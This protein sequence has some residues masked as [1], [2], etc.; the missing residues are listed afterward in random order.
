MRRWLGVAFILVSVA[1]GIQAQALRPLTV[2]D[3]L[4]FR[5]AS[6][7]Q[8]SPDG[9]WVALT[10]TDHSIAENKAVSTI[11]L[12]PSAGGAV[13]PLTVSKGSNHSPR[14][15]T[16]STLAF[17]STRDGESQVWIIDVTGGEARKLTT[18][19]SEVS[20]L[21]VSKDGAW[22]AFD[23]EVYPD[24]IDDDCN[25]RR[26]AEVVKRASKAKVFDRLP[27]RVWN[28]WKDG[29]R[30]HV[31]VQ[32][33]AGGPAKDATPGDFDAPPIDLGGAWDYGFSPDGRTLA[34]SKN[35]DP[36][37]ATSTNNDLFVVPVAGGDARRITENPANDAQ[38]LYAPDGRSIAYL[39]M[40]RPGFEAD[41]RV[42]MLYDVATGSRRAISEATDLSFGEM[43][44]S[45][46]GRYLYASADDRGARSV[47]RIAV[48]DGQVEPLLQEGVVTGLRIAPDGRS[49]YFLH[50]RM[51]RPAELYRMD[52]P[53]KKL[54]KLTGF[55]DER[56]KGLD[57]PAK[58]DVWFQGAGAANVHALLLK[59]PG[60]AAGKTYPLIYLIHG[61][62]QGQ[63]ADQFHYRWS[64]QLFASR[65]F[66]VAMVNPRGSTGYGQAFTDQ[67]SGDWGGA[68]YEDL[69][70]GL[71]H[72]VKAYP[73]IDGKRIAA[74]G[75]SYG[76]Y[77]VN[78]MLGQTDRFRCFVSHDGVF[79]PWSMY[80]TTEELWFTEWE[81]KG[82]PYQ[83]P[84]LY[85]RWS[86]LRNAAKFKTP[87][88]VIH[89]QL[90]YRVDVS[91]GFQLFTA[92]QRQGIPSKMLYFPDEGHWVTKP[93]NAVLWYATVLD[94]IDAH[95]K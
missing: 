84:E 81:F 55:N 19:S 79:N 37:V 94:W 50:D 40:K 18:I 46:D 3:L 26:A 9:R 92:L 47:F 83:H 49:L 4:A 43:A 82:T 57:L 44:W 11:V 56:L 93:A 88:L 75:A 14:W 22:I 66:V 68:V 60:F 35:T 28:S 8:V 53:N 77:M 63:W 13:V 7:P 48:K 1:F 51:H 90:D 33:V 41:R 21:Q 78:W 87:T 70:K 69:I 67:I 31:F 32:S 64:A 12:V 16:T 71:D 73:Y 34:Y 39:A 89:G 38:P 2:E 25:Q 95:T 6:D 45:P 58:E 17:M 15:L 62:P 42:I 5:R 27:Y 85:D 72:L 86:P 65:G 52:L 10:V 20:G 23:S 24:C 74:A 61:G 30:S 29:K 91:E 59:P 76:G 36:A 54:T 80:G